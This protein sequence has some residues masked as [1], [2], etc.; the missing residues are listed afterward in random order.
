LALNREVVAAVEAGKFAVYGVD[1]IEQALELLM[2]LSAGERGP[3]GTFPPDSIYGRTVARLDELA[4]IVSNW[5]E[6][7]D[8]SE[9]VHG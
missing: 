6:G 3:E 4:E 1:T 2:G 8:V 9:K 7:E 5:G